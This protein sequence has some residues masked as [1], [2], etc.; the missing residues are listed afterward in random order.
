MIL[1]EYQSFKG[2]TYVSTLSI[3][4]LNNDGGPEIIIGAELQKNKTTICVK[5]SDFNTI[6]SVV[7]GAGITTTS[8]F[9]IDNDGKDEIL[10]GSGNGKLYIYKLENNSLKFITSHDLKEGVPNNEIRG[11]KVLNIKEYER[12]LIVV[13]STGGSFRIYHFNENYELDVVFRDESFPIYSIL[14]ILINNSLK[15]ILGGERVITL[16]DFSSGL[17]NSPPPYLLPLD[18]YEFQGKNEQERIYD[19]ALLKDYGNYSR[20]VCAT[21]SGK[22]LFFDVSSYK[23]NSPEKFQPKIN[24]WKGSSSYS[25]ILFDIDNDN[26]DEI[27]IAGKDESECGCIEIYRFND[28]EY[29]PYLEKV[30]Y[31]NEIYSLALYLKNNEKFLL[32]SMFSYPL[33]VF[34]PEELGRLKGTI[35]HIG[36]DI[37]NMPGE[38]VFF[39]GAGFSLPIFKLADD[40]KNDIMREFDLTNDYLMDY[41]REYLRENN[42]FSKCFNK[43]EIIKRLPLELLLFYIK[44]HRGVDVKRDSVLNFFSRRNET[45]HK[46]SEILAEI[47]ENGDVTTVFTVNYDTLLE[48]R[49]NGQN[50]LNKIVD[51]RDYKSTN[52]CGRNSIIKLHGCITNPDSIAGAL[53]EVCELTSKQKKTID[54]IFNGHKI[55]FVGYSCRDA[56]IFPIL[57]EAIKEYKTECYFVDPSGLNDNVNKLIKLSGSNSS[58]KHIQIESEEF[59]E[60]LNEGIKMKKEGM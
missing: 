57:E 33:I 49:L 12:N 18:D 3:G 17:I 13:G 42:E 8:C 1:K 30:E 16:Y 7:V 26:N 28:I 25:I 58:A 36:Q 52:I 31:E 10:L 23:I 45:V 9:D 53:D 2:G 11:I 59:F 50:K 39:T 19:I 6:D 15:I 20:I 40:V 47:I 5:D 35:K 29:W 32:L 4:D 21:H 56:D 55:I 60:I 34:K 38:Y 46:S 27:I 43:K 44:E 37:A 54:F 51:D 24:T 22:P 48:I 41:F 14:P